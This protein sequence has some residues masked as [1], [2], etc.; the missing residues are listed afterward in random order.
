MKILIGNVTSLSKDG[1][2]INQNTF[3]AMED[4]CEGVLGLS[5]LLFLNFFYMYNRNI[6]LVNLQSTSQES[7]N[8]VYVV[9][10]I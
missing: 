3:F 2:Y 1:G 8:R 6:F 9:K 10:Q 7:S 4:V 5:C